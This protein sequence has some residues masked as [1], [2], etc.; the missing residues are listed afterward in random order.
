MLYGKLNVGVEVALL[1]SWSLELT[2]HQLAG[3]RG[4][5]GLGYDGRESAAKQLMLKAVQTR[6]PVEGAKVIKQC[7]LQNYCKEAQGGLWLLASGEARPDNRCRLY[8]PF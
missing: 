3:M 4:Q 2:P 8:H 1:D 7:F 5:M 6:K